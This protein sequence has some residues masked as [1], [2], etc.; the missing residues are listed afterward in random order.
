MEKGARWVEVADLDAVAYFEDALVLFIDSEDEN[1]PT[2]LCV[3]VNY[4]TLQFDQVQPVGAYLKLNFYLPILDV[5]A[6]ISQRQRLLDEMSPDAIA[7]ML[8]DFNQKKRLA[9][10]NMV[11]L[12]DQYPGWQPG[13]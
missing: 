4:D 7:A 1:V 6:R 8:R 10:K 12:S 11:L 9:Q 2:S 3:Q 5:D 13:G